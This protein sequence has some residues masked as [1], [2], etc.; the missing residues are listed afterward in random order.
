MSLKPGRPGHANLAIGLLAGAAVVFFALPLVGLLV[1]V[2][3]AEVWRQLTAPAVQTALR[4][5]LTVSLTAA[6]L[7]LLLGLPLAYALARLPFPGRG[8]A[9]A[10]VTL[11]MVLP[12]VVG[13]TALLAAF[14]RRGLLGGPL[15]HGL[16]VILPYT[17]G[18]AVL[19]ATFVAAPFLVIT[20][21]GALRGLDPRLEQAA[22][23]LGASRLR[24]VATVVLPAIRP[25]LVA[26]LALCWAR[27][28]GEFGAT[29]TFAGNLQGRTQTMPLA[30]YEALHTSPDG[31]VALSLILL[32]V[33]LALL[34]ALRGHFFKG[35]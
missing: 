7:S 35:G 28:L 24:I 18:A 16:G 6:G 5:S 13:G 9:R 30:V 31:A 25:S 33:S 10:L 27:A 11:P 15:E 23:T 3:P 20:V 14:G 22:A 17:T 12:P 32:A 29:I 2:A 1:R 4:L 34:A 8:L 19:A 26:G 21:E